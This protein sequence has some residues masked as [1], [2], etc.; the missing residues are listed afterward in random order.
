MPRN[1]YTPPGS[2]SE[3]TFLKEVAPPRP[4][5]VF[6][7]LALLAVFGIP[8]VVGV[9]GLVALVV[10][11]G[12]KPLGNSAFVVALAWRVAAL[13]FIVVVLVGL[14]YRRA[15]GRWMAIVVPIGIA[16]FSILGPDTTSYANEAE[17][18]G[19]F[20]GRVI[21]I[22]LLLAWW[23]YALAFSRKARRYFARPPAGEAQAG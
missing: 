17:R 15:W 9:A 22:P 16:A 10:S 23:T 5:A 6:L 3:V 8:C 19:G 1:P 14:Y 4:V 12:G 13:A 11:Q 7:M 18:T 20:L 21:V 2:S